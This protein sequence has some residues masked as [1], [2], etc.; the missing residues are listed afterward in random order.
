MYNDINSSSFNLLVSKMITCKPLAQV[1][2]H[3]KMQGWQWFQSLC[4]LK[5]HCLYSNYTSLQK[6]QNLPADY[7]QFREKYFGNYSATACNFRDKQRDMKLFLPF[8]YEEEIQAC[9]DH[10]NNIFISLRAQ[11]VHTIEELTWSQ[12]SRH[13]KHIT[14]EM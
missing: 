6:L 2:A 12:I 11:E 14:L 9:A 13:L 10:S 5:D 3:G 8:L 1:T 4:D 7:G